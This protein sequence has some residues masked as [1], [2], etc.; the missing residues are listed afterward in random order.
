MTKLPD[1]SYNGTCS[2]TN[3]YSVTFSPA[4]PSITSLNRLYL[5][6]TNAS[7]DLVTVN[8]DGLGVTKIFKSPTEQCGSGDIIASQIYLMQF[9]ST[10]DSGAGGYLILGSVGGTDL[11]SYATTDDLTDGL[12]LKSNKA[13]TFNDKIDD[14]TLILSDADYKILT[15]NKA[16][17]LSVI[18][19]PNSSVAFPIGTI[20]SLKRIGV[21]VL[22]VSQG[23]GVTV[24]ATAVVLTDPGQNIIFSLIKTGTD[25]WD[26]QNGVPVGVRLTWTP[27]GTGYTGGTYTGE[28][29]VIGKMVWFKIVTTAVSASAGTTYTLSLPIAA[30]T[31]DGQ[32]GPM[33]YHSDNSVALIGGIWS[34]SGASTVL[35]LYRS[36]AFGAWTNSNNRQSHMSG[37]YLID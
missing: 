1:Y 29:I 6:F 20:I 27:A 37:F 2:G 25:I 11:S 35:N 10:L 7:T 3:S 34:V 26:L 18:V 19:P 33:T 21:G 23:A 24:N 36:A 31:G 22:T 28:Y 16:T 5:K 14:Y 30:R 4:L 9:D 32:S 12:A 8:P 15:F 13:F 17:A